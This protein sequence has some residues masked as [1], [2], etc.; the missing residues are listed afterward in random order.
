MIPAIVVFIYLAVV[1]CIGS[2][3]FRKG[4]ANTEDFFLANRTIGSM[5][6]F[7]SLFATN[8]KPTSRGRRK[9]GTT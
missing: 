7:L 5:V 4:K 3:A 2:V 8:M 6:F 1:L 9:I